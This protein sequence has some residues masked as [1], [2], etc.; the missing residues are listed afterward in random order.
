MRKY[1]SSQQNRTNP[2]Y[3][4]IKRG[5]YYYSR[6]VPKDLL[7]FYTKPKIVQSLRTK[8]LLQAKTSSKHLTAKLDDYWLGLRLK[9]MEVPCPHL[10]IG[11]A[12]ENYSTCLTVI[13]AQ[14]LYLSLKGQGRQ[15]M[16]FNTTKR[17]IGYL[18]KCLGNRPLEQYTTADASHLRQH[19]ISK[20][21]SNSSLQRAFGVIK[22]VITFAIM[23][24][25]LNITNPFSGVYLPTATDS[26][27]RQPISKENLKR[28]QL[29]CFKLDDDIRYLVAL[30]SDTGLRLA[31]AAGLMLSD[32]N[33]DNEVPYVSIRP[34]QHR[35]LKTGSSERLVPLVGA[36]LWAC[37]QIISKS[38]G[39]YCFPRYSSEK[40]CKSN[41]ASAAINKWLKSIAGEEALI[42]GMR[43]SFRDRLRDIQ[44]PPDLTD[45]LGGWSLQT[46]GQSYGNGYSLEKLYEWMLKISL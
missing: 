16:F 43:H 3:T 26:K 28:L 25:G 13:E 38:S 23:E 40:G 35:S 1:F 31:E 15:E 8:S 2:Q 37:K 4:F 24:T 17:N 6:Q 18:V 7:R 34:H 12:R 20:G 46:V 10:I 32:I 22:A 45:Q 9:D 44:A 42:H 11:K 5:V 39:E 21:L 19:L 14:E 27:K 30:I 29:E 33:L 36:S 41:S